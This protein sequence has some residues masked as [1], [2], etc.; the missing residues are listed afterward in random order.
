M[1]GSMQVAS[2]AYEP[3]SKSDPLIRT[4]SLHR[5]TYIPRTR[6]RRGS[7]RLLSV[8]RTNAPGAGWG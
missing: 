7:P 3:F 4:G 5:D 2:R 8:G 1:G 6:A